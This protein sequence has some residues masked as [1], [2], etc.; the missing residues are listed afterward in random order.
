[1]GTMGRYHAGKILSEGVSNLRLT[2]VCDSAADLSGDFPDLKHFSD[3]DG[4]FASGEVD[5]V[6][7]ATPHY[8]HTELGLRAL[9]AG[10]HVLVE[11]PISVHKADCE[12]LLAAHTDPNLVFAAMLNMRTVGLY[13]KV[14]ELLVNG[15]IGKVFR[16]TWTVT[17]W[18]RSQA[19]YDSG[20]WRG[21][22]KGEGGGV[23]LNQCPHQLDLWQ[24]LFGMPQRVTA[25]IGI[26]RHHMLEVED[27]VT[28]LMEYEDGA[29]G[30]FITSTGEAPGV[31]R[32]EISGD[33]GK[34]TIENGSI[35]FQRLRGSLKEFTKESKS[36]LDPPECWD[37]I[38]PHTTTHNQHLHI[39]ANFADAIVN[40]VPLL[41]PA[42]EGM[43]S[44]ELG[45]AMLLSGLER[46]QVA[47]P[48]DGA[49]FEATLKSLIAKS[50]I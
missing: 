17:D 23:L 43:K 11:K 12:R 30:V 37:I 41:A 40:G 42:S 34:L 3:P 48:L 33:H 50:H 13:R 22:W 29:T 1:M 38:V 14:K 45:N 21:T 47:L 36:R 18:F 10:L 4:F 15:D 2:A 26:G 35:R 19:Y 6:L 5:A 20:G 39:I 16:I 9:E 44:V 7:I 27:D 31:N 25:V 46:K 24:W 49:A 28:A 32:L 8:F